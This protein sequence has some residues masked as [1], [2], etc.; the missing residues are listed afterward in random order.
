MVQSRRSQGR[1]TKLIVPTMTEKKSELKIALDAVDKAIDALDSLNPEE[2]SSVKW[3][4]ISVKREAE[5]LSK[6]IELLMKLQTAEGAFREF[7]IMEDDGS[8]RRMSHDE[9]HRYIM[10]YPMK[11]GF[12]L[13]DTIRT[14]N[15]R[16]DEEGYSKR[17]EEI[18][19]E[20]TGARCIDEHREDTAGN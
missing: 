9:V 13:L 17:A 1:A 15:R 4:L 8:F 20:I 3:E 2:G 7:V 12:D 19:R 6:R 11:K 14:I 18:F 16:L 5:H 10:G